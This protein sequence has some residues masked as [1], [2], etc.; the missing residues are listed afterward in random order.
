MKKQQHNHKRIFIAIMILTALIFMMLG[1]MAK[2]NQVES[3]T[4]I[5]ILEHNVPIV[6][7]I[8]SIIIT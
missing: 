1:P 4:T 3:S 8:K 6:T 2:A 7:I 5:F